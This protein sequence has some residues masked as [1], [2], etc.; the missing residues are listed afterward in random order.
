[1]ARRCSDS[2]C[3][4]IVSCWT[5][6]LTWLLEG[7]DRLS[8]STLVLFSI[9]VRLGLAQNVI[10][11]CDGVMKVTLVMKVLNINT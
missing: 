9:L 10:N 5:F 3:S 11:V 4:M 7:M 6:R 1:V 2:D 8:G